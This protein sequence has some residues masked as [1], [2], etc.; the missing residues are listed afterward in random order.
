MD[1]EKIEN[2]YAQLTE[3]HALKE[4]HELAADEPRTAFMETWSWI[5]L[6]F[7]PT[8]YAKEYH[9][10]CCGHP[11]GQNYLGQH[12]E[13]DGDIVD[14]DLVRVACF[15]AGCPAHSWEIVWFK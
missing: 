7:G 8:T 14:E 13:D 11:Y 6:A 9:C 10:W 2:K 12:R 3:E 15:R 4:G 5:S 1:I